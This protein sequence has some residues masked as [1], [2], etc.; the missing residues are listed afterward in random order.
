MVINFIRGVESEA[1]ALTSKFYKT[2]NSG[3]SIKIVTDSGFSNAV[4]KT[5]D[6]KLRKKVFGEECKIYIYRKKITQTS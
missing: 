5:P 3:K 2:E 1:D 6:S 4:K